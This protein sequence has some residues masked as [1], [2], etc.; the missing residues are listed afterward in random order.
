MP[1]ARYRFSRSDSIK[2]FLSK[3][4]PSTDALG[5]LAVWQDG[6]ADRDFSKHIDEDEQL[7]AELSWNESDDSAGPS[8]DD[9]CSKFGVARTHE[10]V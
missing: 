9:A 8:L 6:H 3:N 1:K 2:G 5:A 4:R 10:I 7:V